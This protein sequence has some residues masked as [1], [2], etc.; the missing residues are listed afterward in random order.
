MTS[1]KKNIDEIVKSALLNYEAAAPADVW[2]NIV[3][4]IK[5]KKRVI[6]PI[7]FGWAATIAVLLTVSALWYYSQDAKRLSE[8]ENS[9]PNNIEI[10]DA[11]KNEQ[12]QERIDNIDH[13]L[14]ENDNNKSHIDLNKPTNITKT[15]TSSSANKISD[16]AVNSKDGNQK[17]KDS[18]SG[19]INNNIDN[20]FLI[21]DNDKSNINNPK[22]IDNSNLIADNIVVDSESKKDKLFENKK[23]TEQEVSDIKSLVIV[24][25]KKQQKDLDNNKLESSENEIALLPNNS[26]AKWIVGVS[27]SPVYS[28]RSISQ[29]SID[30]TYNWGG[31]ENNEANEQ[32][33][34]AYAGGLN[35]A[36]DINKWSFSSGVHYSKSGQQTSNINANRFVRNGDESV[37]FISTSINSIQIVQSRSGFSGIS[38]NID[39]SSAYPDIYGTDPSATTAIL[40]QEFEFVEIPLLARYSLI[41]KEIDFQIVSGLSTGYLIK[42]TNTLNYINEEMNLGEAQNINKINYNS[43]IGVALQI[44]VFGNVKIRLEPI[45]KYALSSLNKD[46]SVSYHPYSFAFY[47]GIYYEF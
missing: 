40:N 35:V 43:L 25:N 8:A 1:K 38:G 13:A 27:A 34:I 28:Y 26:K 6:I 36:Y 7:W 39:G 24:D 9:V 20:S 30:Y 47:S 22:G 2:S 41:Q 17:V 10:I 5:S 11:S 42:N 21:A 45:F 46:Y 19:T 32:A 18:P 29:Q 23:K 16:I 33:I 31:G 4:N 12:S 3:P 15:G 44:P 14:Y 37:I